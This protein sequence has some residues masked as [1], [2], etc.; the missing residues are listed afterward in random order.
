MKI[1]PF[2]IGMMCLVTVLGS[3]KK[4]TDI[5]SLVPEEQL[6]SEMKQDL[7]ASLKDA[8]R[9]AEVFKFDAQTGG[10]F[11]TSKGTILTVAPN[12]F[13]KANGGNVTGTV[14]LSFKEI[15]EVSEMILDDKPTNAELID[16]KDTLRSKPAVLESLGEF[17]AD[18]RLEGEPLQLK[19][20]TA[21]EVEIPQP[22]E[23][24]LESY[25]VPLWTGDTTYRKDVI[26]RDAENREVFQDTPIPLQAGVVWKSTYTSTKKG[27]EQVNQVQVPTFSFGI[28]KLGEWRNCDVLVQLTRTT[29]VLGYFNI[30]YDNGESGYAGTQPNMLFFK[31]KGDKVLVKLYNPILNA[32]EGKKGFLSYQNTF[33]IGMEG[34]FLALVQK[35]GKYYAQKKVTTIAEPENGK[36]YVGI[37][38]TLTEV[39]KK[40]MLDLI[41]SMDNE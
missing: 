27:E 6:T 19:P 24:V 35:D 25:E 8:A 33:N 18:A 12:I 38:F 14:E 16:K 15:T 11:T 41:A 34:T 39:S 5:E 23:Q 28:P 31:K 37:Y 26:G 10:K 29:T 7:R 32:P 9:K 1:T 13:K 30:F 22:E 20:N 36:D 21:I 2:Y 40:Q 17:K 4:K 3:C